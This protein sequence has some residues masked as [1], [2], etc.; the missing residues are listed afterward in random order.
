MRVSKAKKV[1]LLSFVFLVSL[2]VL[3][4]CGGGKNAEQPTPNQEQP[5]TENTGGTTEQGTTENIS[6]SITVAGSTAMQPL[7]EKVAQMFMEK[8]P[9]VQITVQGGG[10]G[11][12]L[13]Q[14]A[15][16][17]I[18]VGNSDV[19]AEEK[20]KPEETKDLV[21]H[22]VAVVAMA[23]VAHPDVGV[24]NLTKQQLIDIFTGKITN[25]KD[26]GG[27]DQKITL[28]NRPASSGTRATFKKYALDGAEEASGIEEDS[29]GTVR[30]IISS[31]PGAIGYLAFSYLDGSVKALKID[32]VEPTEANVVTNDYKVWAYQ[33]MYTKGEPTGAVKAFLDYMMS[34]EVQS[35]PVVEGGYIPISKMKVERDAQGN[36]TQ[37]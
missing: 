32:G 3:A 28:V 15:Q 16:G 9:Q 35:G 31:T 21:D 18:D 2:T 24:D 4:A 17:A 12:G 10:S 1:W 37:K 26:V 19:F 34:D 13:S 33:H 6:G 5:G 27:K 11:T 29:S 22:K 36:V 8:H 14:V 25:W 30:Q 23:A 20:L 7:V